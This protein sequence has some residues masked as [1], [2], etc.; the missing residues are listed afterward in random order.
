MSTHKDQA[1][2]LIE[3]VTILQPSKSW[4]PE[5]I[6]T[7][8]VRFKG[9]FDPAVW[10]RKNV[11]ITAV[12]FG[13]IVIL[14][15][16][17]G[18]PITAQGMIFVVI[19]ALIG[20]AITYVM[21]RNQNWIITNRAVYVNRGRPMLISSARKVVGFGST[22]RLTGRWGVGMTLLGVQNAAEVRAVLQG[23]AT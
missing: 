13:V 19:L 2:K 1:D 11:A 6:E 8:V 14:A 18:R 22:V 4:P 9:S 5:L 21:Y 23:R 10:V 7:E 15:A 12:V 16:A 20:T 3:E 17:L